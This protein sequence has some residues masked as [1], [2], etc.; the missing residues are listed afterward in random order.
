MLPLIVYHEYYRTIKSKLDGRDTARHSSG[1][2]C[3]DNLS[4]DQGDFEG[5]ATCHSAKV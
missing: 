5:V 1:L 3:Q 2:Q 4:A